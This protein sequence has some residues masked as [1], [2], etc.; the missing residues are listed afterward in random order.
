[1]RKPPILALVALGTAIA[2]VC[3]CQSPPQQ[4]PDHVVDIRALDYFFNAPDTID[5]GVVT[6]R[7]WQRGRTFHNLEVVRL[8]SGHTAGEWHQAEAL[9]LAPA[10]GNAPS[11]HTRGGLADLVPGR[12]LLTTILFDSGDY[13]A[14]ALPGPDAPGAR[15]AFRIR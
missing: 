7:L 13:I 6:L 1:M 2:L 12:T 5:E 8:D 10:A 3:A 4:P 9:G 15:T 14:Y 11:G